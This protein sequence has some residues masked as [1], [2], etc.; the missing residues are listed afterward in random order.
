MLDKDPARLTQFGAVEITQNGITV[1][2]FR[3]ENGTCR[4]VAALAAVWAI[5]R[6]QEELMKCLERPGGGNICID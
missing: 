5:G 2:G 4:D 6:L 3:A 1:S